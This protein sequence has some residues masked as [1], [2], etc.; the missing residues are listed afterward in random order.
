MNL[1]GREVE[2][3]VIQTMKGEVLAIISDENII[4]KDEISVVVDF[5]N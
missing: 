1:N 2:Q 5:V 4:E 3:I